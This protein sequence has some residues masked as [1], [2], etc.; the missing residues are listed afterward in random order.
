MAQTESQEDKPKVLVL[1]AQQGCVVFTACWRAAHSK[2][3]R[4]RRGRF[5][6]E[7]L[8][9]TLEGLVKRFD[10]VIASAERGPCTGSQ[11][12]VV[13]ARVAFKDVKRSA[14]YVGLAVVG[15]PGSA[16]LADDQAVLG[17]ARMFWMADKPIGGIC[18]GPY[19]LAAAGVLTGKRATVWNGGGPLPDYLTSHG[20]TYTG[21][22]VTV[23]G[24]IVTADGPS[25]SHQFGAALSDILV[26]GT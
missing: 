17:I 24:R 21:D 3:K 22:G 12:G 1:V 23:D 2:R 19:V 6:D 4:R 14:D 10:V 9:G 15:G 7:E 11:G 8:N 18:H 26:G 5:Q 16:G 13:E 20:A 25:S